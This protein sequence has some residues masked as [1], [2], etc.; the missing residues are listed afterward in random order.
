MYYTG[1]FRCVECPATLVVEM[2]DWADLGSGTMTP[3]LK[4]K[5]K[6]WSCVKGVWRCPVH[7]PHVHKPDWSTARPVDGTTDVFD[8]WCSCGTSGSFIVDPKDI[9]WEE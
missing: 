5:I 3:E 7:A 8:V 4:E 2:S 9:N 6:G 1:T